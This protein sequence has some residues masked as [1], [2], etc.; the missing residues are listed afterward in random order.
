MAFTVMDLA[1][2]LSLDSSDYENK[3]G[4]M[5]GVA[6]S[7]G[8]LVSTAL[9]TRIGVK[10][11]GALKDFATESIQTGATFDKSM[12]QVAATMGTTVGEIENLREFAQEMGRTTAFSATEA[13]DA[14]NYM[15]LAGYDAETSMSMLPNVLNLAAAG[16]FDLA[17]ASDMITDTQTAFG[18]SLDRTSQMVDEMAK[19]A[20]TG[21]TSVEQLGDAFL[22]VGGLAKELNGG[23]VQFTNGVVT[24]NKEVD[25]VQELEIALTAMANAGIKGSEAGTHMRNMIMKLTSPTKEGQETFEALGVSVLDSAGNMRSLNEIFTDLNGSLSTMTQGDKLNAISD[26]FNAR[27][28]A[29]AEALLA[30]VEQDWDNIGMA[31]LDAEGAAEQMAQTQLDNLAGDITLFKS[32]LEGAQIAISDNLAPTLRQFVQFGSE[33]LSKLTDAFK[34]GGLS[35]AMDVLKEQISKGATALAEGL[36][37]FVET[38]VEIVKTIGS[39][40]I[41]AIPTLLESVV[42]I[43]QYL[44]EEFLTLAPELLE[45]GMELI[46]NIGEGFVQGIPTFFETALPQLLTIVEG[47]RENAGQF[48]DTGIEFI[49]NLVHGLVNGLPQLI[50]YVPQIITNIAGIINDNMPKILAMGL[51][52]IVTLGMGIIQNIPVIIAN[53][54]NIVQAIVS[55]IQAFN[56]LNLGSKVIQL[57]GSGFQALAQLPVNIIRNIGQNVINMLKGGFSWSGLG[58]AIIQGIA[59]GISNAGHMIMDTLLNIVQGAWSAVKSFFGIASPSKLMR[60]TIGKFIP[61]GMAVGIE[62][63][64]DSVMKAMDDLSQLTMDSYNPELPEGSITNTGAKSFTINVYGAVGQDVQELA[65]IVA[66]RINR[67]IKDEEMVYA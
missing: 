26:I 32:A 56:W 2:K 5:G 6:T 50:E 51:Q 25:G 7:A 9:K 49:M 62:E 42:T 33:T 15:A 58:Q 20:S 30:A 52:I 27:D 31:I 57:L 16:S 53:M 64:S 45:S 29:S 48:V 12:S 8:K 39:G 28:I 67:G 47:I 54:G 43:G 59:S 35:D 22:T 21:N 36:P 65:D 1:A 66:D 3:L 23:V 19:A 46:R 24:M 17:R 44:F 34:N 55:V 61:E 38:G 11:V 41:E 13:A 10:A 14:L 4:A 63:N 40:L 18:I 37:Q 60:D